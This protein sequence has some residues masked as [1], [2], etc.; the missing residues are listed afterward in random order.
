MQEVDQD[1]IN[2]ERQEQSKNKVRRMLVDMRFRN[3]YERIVP[4]GFCVT[5]KGFTTNYSSRGE[6]SECGTE[7][8]ADI[9]EVK[10]ESN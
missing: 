5:C 3:P 4:E 2:E 8:T 1:L 6:C 7:V 9:S 10:N